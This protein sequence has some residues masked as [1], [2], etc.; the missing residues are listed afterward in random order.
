MRSGF[1]LLAV[2]VI[3]LALASCGRYRD[4][5]SCQDTFAAGDTQGFVILEGGLARG[6]QS[7][8]TWYRCNAG[9]QFRGDSCHGESLLLN[10]QEARAFL[11]EVSA[12]SGKT[13]RLPTVDEM[14]TIRVD[15][16]E[17]PAVN[18]Q[19]FPALYSDSYWNHDL[20]G[21]AGPLGCSTNTFNG[22]SFCR[23]FVEH[24]RPFLMVLDEPR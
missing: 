15:Q 19:V 17:N 23:E 2:A 11:S 8:L 1:T 13:W 16:C 5:P 18:P 7:G 4:K 9:Q 22:V 14:K 10:L 3:G 12:A 6:A 24:K 21:H 20:S